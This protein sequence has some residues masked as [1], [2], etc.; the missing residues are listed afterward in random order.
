MVPA[1]GE[2]GSGAVC[3]LPGH[4]SA[5]W[6]MRRSSPALTPPSPAVCDLSSGDETLLNALGQCEPY[7][8]RRNRSP[9]PDKADRTIEPCLAIASRRA[10]RMIG[11]R[12]RESECLEAPSPGS[13]SRPAPSL[14]V[15][16]VADRLDHEQ[17]PC[18]LQASGRHRASD[19]QDADRDGRFTL[20]YRTSSPERSG[21]GSSAH[22]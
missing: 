22:A 21:S 2:R 15:E 4:F 8:S 3:R 20:E 13:C 5:Y 16:R 7:H 1:Q 12:R 19:P 14:V 9:L 6:A 18:W 11:D 17:R 10:K